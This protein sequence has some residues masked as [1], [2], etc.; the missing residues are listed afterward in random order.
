MMKIELLCVDEEL[1]SAQSTRATQ[2]VLDEHRLAWRVKNLVIRYR[3]L[4]K[5]LPASDQKLKDLV[6][7]IHY[8]TSKG[9]HRY[10]FSEVFL[11]GNTDFRTAKL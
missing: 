8:L 6:R 4:V 3:S 5:A 7:E 10:P 2:V 9:R 1:D 11:S